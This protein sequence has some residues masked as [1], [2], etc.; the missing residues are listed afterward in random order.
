[1]VCEV[2]RGSVLQVQGQRMNRCGWWS[3]VSAVELESRCLRFGLRPELWLYQG[4]GGGLRLCFFY[5]HYFFWYQLLTADQFPATAHTCVCLPACMFTCCRIQPVY[6]KMSKE[7][8]WVVFKDCIADA[9]KCRICSLYWSK[10]KKKWKDRYI[11]I[12]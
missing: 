2:Q 4:S 1:M 12:F 8:P 10:K 6:G 9:G 11:L 5:I 3:P 7:A